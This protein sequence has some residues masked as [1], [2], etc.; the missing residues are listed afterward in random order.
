VR[1][2]ADRIKQA[3]KSLAAW[4][5]DKFWHVLALALGGRTVAE[6]QEV[7]TRKEFLD[8]VEF[9][10]NFPFDDLHRFHRPAAVIAASMGGKD[11]YQK[12]LD[13]LAPEP[14]PEGMSAVDF[15]VYKAFGMRPKVKE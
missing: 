5:E 9:N 11:A 6:W 2:G 13:H 1:D 8:W 14:V 15:S 3:G 12:A 10:K 4:G 7:M